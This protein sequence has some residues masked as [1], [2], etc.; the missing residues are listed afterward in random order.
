MGVPWGAEMIVTV[1]LIKFLI[2][3]YG[4]IGGGEGGGV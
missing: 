3:C 1:R 4:Y 2:V